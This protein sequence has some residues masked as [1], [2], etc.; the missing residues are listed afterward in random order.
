[1]EMP[2]TFAAAE[3][4]QR[5]F[6]GCS[7]GCDVGCSL[8][9]WE[10]WIKLCTSEK[11]MPVLTDTQMVFPAPPIPIAFTTHPFSSY[12]INS[13]SATSDLTPELGG[14]WFDCSEIDTGASD[15]V[16]G[17]HYP[18]HD[19]T[20]SERTFL[21]IGACIIALMSVLLEEKALPYS[22]RSTFLLWYF[23]E[24]TFH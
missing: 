5:G 14:K 3:C 4:V 6:A 21:C 24:L 10:E 7:E 12:T 11:T 17:R 19:L 2:R 15:Q 22:F 16:G 18:M 13:T 20:G 1:M 9:E 23:E 8:Q